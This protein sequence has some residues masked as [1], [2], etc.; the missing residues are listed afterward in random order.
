M[1][2]QKFFLEQIAKIF[3]YFTYKVNGQQIGHEILQLYEDLTKFCLEMD[4]VFLL[5]V[6]ATDSKIKLIHFQHSQAALGWANH[7]CS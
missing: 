5:N 4:F 7:A 6:L 1:S 2:Q 3:I